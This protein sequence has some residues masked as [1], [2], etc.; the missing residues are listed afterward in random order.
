[1]AGYQLTSGQMKAIR[2]TVRIVMNQF[3]G[4]MPSAAQSQVQRCLTVRLSS[5]LSA[6]ANAADDPGIGTGVV[7]AKQANG[8]MRNTSQTI[9]VINR[10][11]HISL[12]QDTLAVAMW[13]DGE[14]RLIAGDCDPL[15]FSTRLTMAGS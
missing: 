4:T 9:S 2:E 15:S 6:A 3:R 12:E 8:E 11:E 1:M 5:A 7:V 14:W 10:F 13:I